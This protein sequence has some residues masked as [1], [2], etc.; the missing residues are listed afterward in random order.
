MD[1]LYLIAAFS[2]DKMS[3]NGIAAV[4]SYKRTEEAF[5]K[6]VSK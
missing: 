3:G 6:K 2:A 5:M 4:Y 1:K